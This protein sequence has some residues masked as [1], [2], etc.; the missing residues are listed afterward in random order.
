MIHGEEIPM[1][2]ARALP[3]LVLAF[4][5]VFQ[6]VALAQTETGQITGTVSDPQGAVV[7]GATVT[8]TNNDTGA[9]R[10]SQTTGE[11]T[12]LV[13]SLQPGNYDVKIE[14]SGFAARTVP[15][16]VTVGTKVTVDVELVVSG[17]GEAVD[18]V[19]GDQ[20]VQVNTENQVLATVVTEKQIKELPTLTR[21]PYVLVQLAGTAVDIDPEAQ[22]PNTTASDRG[23]GFNINGQRSAST[24]VLLD[25]A[26]NNDT[27]G[28][29]IGNAV[30]LVP[31]S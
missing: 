8:V 2:L 3:I 25:G 10:T 27:Y 30:P 22:D 4:A 24:N 17:G 1:R 28:S 15:V 31:L 14:S 21:N 11:G 16:R 20:G 12:Y 5:M 23:V 13:P 9:I 7:A 19:A 18:I 26:D 29:D 6:G